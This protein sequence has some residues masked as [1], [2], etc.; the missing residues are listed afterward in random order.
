M[1]AG[2]ESTG[3]ISVPAI[4]VGVPSALLERRPDVAAAERRMAAANAQVGVARAAIFPALTLSASAGLQNSSLAHLF[5][6][7]SR[8]WSIGPALAAAIFDAG[9][10]KA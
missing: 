6:L 10:R 7:P 1:P 9:L 5:S 3:P 8:V 2:G 4:P